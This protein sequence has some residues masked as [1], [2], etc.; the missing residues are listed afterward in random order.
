MKDS[1]IE[2]IGMIPDGWSLIK[3][4]QIADPSVENSFMDGDWIESPYIDNQGIRYYTTGNVG[5]GEFKAQGSGFITEDTFD[6][7][8]CKLAYPGDLVFSR[9]NAPYGRSC[10]LPSESE[11]YV[12]AVDI[13][14]LR[15]RRHFDKR[16]ICYVTQCSGYQDRAFDMARGTAMKRIS[17]SNLGMIQV[18]VP[19][20]REQCRIADFLD[21]KCASIDD[22]I[23][24]T[25]ESIEEY[26]KLKQAVI[27]EA[28]TKGVRGKRPMKAS[29]IDWIDEIPKDWNTDKLKRI[30][31]ERMENNDPVQTS[32][33]LSLSIDTGVTLYA[34]KT[35]NLDRFKEDVSQYKLAH[36][37]DLVMNSMNVIVG[38]VGVSNYFG[39]V[40]P[41]YYTYYDHEPD[42]VTARYMDYVFRT[43]SLRALLYRLGKGIYAIDRGDGK[44]NTCRLKVSREDMRSLKLPLPSVKEQREIVQYLDKK[45][46][47]IDTLI[48]KK[49]QFIDELT[50]YKKSLIYEYVTGK[51]EVPA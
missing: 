50:A 24:K 43:K 47:A 31:T 41:A 44:V 20:D 32:E 6:K 37:G 10:I 11:R 13:V 19:N 28:V 16:Y 25:N 15:P 35:T 39:C 49:Q 4:K 33:R 21:A 14:I 27:T 2:W 22:V 17:R 8:N 18:P 45:C 23:A 48:S 3:I 38:A 26:K 1:G 30:L 5:D 51:K 34:E 12:V 9:L 7:L 46:A 36:E 40:S 42:H 29:D